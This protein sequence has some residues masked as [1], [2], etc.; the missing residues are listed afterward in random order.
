VEQV[1][2]EVENAGC[3]AKKV[4]IQCLIFHL[5][6]GI[7]SKKKKKV[8]CNS[9]VGADRFVFVVVPSRFLVYN[10][11]RQ[12]FSGIENMPIPATKKRI[13]SRS[14]PLC[15][16]RTCPR[17]ENAPTAPL[18]SRCIAGKNRSV[19]NPGDAR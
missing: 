13:R 16:A 7:R 12:R 18:V 17:C 2:C 10:P 11:C 14:R 9:R 1:D 8:E 19:K 15:V 5:V 3:N 6:G 4:V